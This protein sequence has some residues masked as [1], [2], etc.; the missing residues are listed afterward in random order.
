MYLSIKN[1]RFS[2]F[3]FNILYRYLKK[4][5]I[6]KSSYYNKN[7]LNKKEQFWLKKT[8]EL[9]KIIMDKKEIQK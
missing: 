5:D 9:N 1:L 2:G 3:R 4:Y 6:L 7:E 8:N